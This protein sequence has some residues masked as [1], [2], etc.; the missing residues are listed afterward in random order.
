MEMDL[1]MIYVHCQQLLL[2]AKEE[3]ENVQA[4]VEGKNVLHNK[5]TALIWE[6]NL[7]TI[8]VVLENKKT[9]LY[10]KLLCLFIDI[11]SMQA[12]GR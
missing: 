4:L 6:E 9:T 11:Q 10:F 8:A 5:V 12:A 2:F 3:K 7:I 1:E